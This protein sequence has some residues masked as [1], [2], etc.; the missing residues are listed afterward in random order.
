LQKLSE[1]YGPARI[2]QITLSWLNRISRRLHVLEVKD[3]RDRLAGILLPAGL[4]MI[5]SLLFRPIGL[6][7]LELDF[8]DVGPGLIV[9]LLMLAAIAVLTTLQSRHLGLLLSMTGTGFALAI[10]FA[11]L[12][13]PD[14]AL[15]AVL[16]ETALSLLFIATLALLPGSVLRREAR[17]TQRASTPWFRVFA[18]T[19]A[20]SLV[21]IVAWT[22]L[23]EPGAEL[24]AEGYRQISLLAHA[25]NIVAAIL[26]DFRGLDTVGEATVL[27][28]ALLAVIGLLRDL[29][30]ERDG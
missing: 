25:D 16:V 17:I 2:L 7:L 27:V 11:L 21:F 22:T 13:A 9:M 29:R 30:R 18:G 10:I 28:I 12:G 5:L 1:R 19:V 8:G 24:T 14:V 6:R 4:L 23:A 20:A 15:V 26:V 3:L